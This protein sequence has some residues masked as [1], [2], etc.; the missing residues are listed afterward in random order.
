MKLEL[1]DKIK[2]KGVS[3][4]EKVEA[5]L[6]IVFQDE[7]QREIYRKRYN[8]NVKLLENKENEKLKKL[9]DE[10]TEDYFI[11]FDAE[12]IGEYCFEEADVELE[13]ATRDRLSR[14]RV[15]EKSNQK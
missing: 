1:F 14:D 12:K 9:F 5:L 3:E 11:G 15:A 7:Q 2:S 8:A 10:L 6:K 4:T 13:S